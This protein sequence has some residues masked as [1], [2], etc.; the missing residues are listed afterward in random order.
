MP[1]YE[2]DG[3]EERSR[4]DLVLSAA[5]VL[6]SV[7]LLVLPLPV[8]QGIS[9]GLRATVLAPFIWTQESLNRTRIRAVD[10]EMLQARYD[11][12]VA[13][14]ASQA[15]LGAENARLRSL[16]ELKERTGPAFVSAS[17]IR[18]GTRGSESMFLL[19]VGSE[20]GVSVNDPVVAAEGLVGLVREVGP[21]S[22]LALDWTHP[23]F[24]VMA[25]SLDGEVLGIVEARTGA[26]REQDRLVLDGIPFY[27]SLEP[28]LVLVTSGQ[29]AVFPR[30][31][32]VGTVLS[33]AET[34]AGWR[35][36]YWVE[37]AVRVGSVTHVL[38]ITGEEGLPV[39][40]LAHLWAPAPP[41]PLE[42]DALPD[43]E[44]VEP[45]PP[46]TDADPPP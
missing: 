6:A 33:L 15:P 17:A 19:D 46:A 18:P 16:L 45:E 13:L 27:T 10:I 41:E 20:H 14:L 23:D 26:F 37:P 8:Q 29:G 9:S 4:R 32:R 43:P 38:V 30:G 3:S 42:G 24:A 36:G 34:E 7:I 28:G 11:S 35:R 1:P 12:T 44:P 25:M 40:D 39:S 31:I 5:W 22:S 21:R 2:V